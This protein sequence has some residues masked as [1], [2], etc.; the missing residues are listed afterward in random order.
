MDNFA[1]LHQVPLISSDVL[2]EAMDTS[3]QRTSAENASDEYMPDYDEEDEFDDATDSEF[4]GSLSDYCSLCMRTTD[5]EENMSST[6]RWNYRNE[7]SEY[8]VRKRYIDAR[9]GTLTVESH[10]A[11]DIPESAYDIFMYTLVP[12]DRMIIRKEEMLFSEAAELLRAARE[13]DKLSDGT[14]RT[15]SCDL[16]PYW[17]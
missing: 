11:P 1:Y 9:H 6:N 13:R 16:S 3:Q 7:D 12:I 14:S 5:D 4:D 2:V 8:K 10:A 17:L 15:E